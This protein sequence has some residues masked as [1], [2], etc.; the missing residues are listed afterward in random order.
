M[1]MQELRVLKDA[2]MCQP[3]RWRGSAA[4]A[5]L[6]CLAMSGCSNWMKAGMLQIR[7]FTGFNDVSTASLVHVDSTASGQT[8]ALAQQ[9]QQAYAAAQTTIEHT[10]GAGF[11]SPN[12]YVCASEA[13]YAKYVMIADSSAET[14]QGGNTVI[15]NAVRLLKNDS[16]LPIFT[17]ELSHIFWFQHGQRC[18]P[19]WWLEGMAVASSGGGAEKVSDAQARQLLREGQ[20][21]RPALENGCFKPAQRGSLSWAAYYRQAAMFVSYL[22]ESAPRFAHALEL[23]RQ[24]ENVG[25]A[26]QTAYGQPVAELWEQW[27]K[28][29]MVLAQ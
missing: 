18:A 25:I 3:S 29:E 5:V 26:L 28:K 27:R 9:L 1:T 19:R 10:H 17:H 8:L 2:A 14:G 22:R 11:K 4:I 21:F 16:G 23:M 12:V 7:P 6:C 15:L 20:A 24:G 13:C